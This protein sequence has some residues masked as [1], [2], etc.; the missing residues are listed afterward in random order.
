MKWFQHQSNARHNLKFQPILEEFGLEGYGMYWIL[1]EL[2]AEQS[3]NYLITSQKKWKQSLIRTSGVDPSLL[4]RML[5][6]FAD[7]NLIS[8]KWLN[9]GALAIPKMRDYSDN[10][11][12]RP[13]SNYRATTEQLPVDKIRRDKIRIDKK[14]VTPHP[15]DMKLAQLL[16]DL[17]KKNTPNWY[18]KPNLNDWADE[19]R[20]LREIDKQPLEVIEKVIKWCQ[21]DDFWYKNILS[22]TKLRKQFPKLLV[23]MNEK[24]K[25]PFDYITKKAKETEEYFK[26]LN[27]KL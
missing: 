19:I 13:H 21:D 11:T 22:T 4:D 23:Q 8:K 2:V 10:W 9:K 6:A 24:K 15:S 16:Y 20:K 27:K 18:H 14:K 5:D 17:I 12:K 3:Q 26:K 7:V 25:V 1:C